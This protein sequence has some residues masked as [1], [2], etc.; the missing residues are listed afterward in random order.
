MQNFWPASGYA[1]LT[2]D[3]RGWLCPSEA[4][5]RRLVV[6]LPQLAL[7]EE[8]CPAEIALHQA[9]ADAPL[10]SV[11]EAQLAAL[12][13]ADARDNYRLFLSFRDTLLAAGTLE[14]YYL[15][16]MR[17][18]RITVPPLFVDLIVQAI[19]RHLL[20]D[21]H[22]AFEARA[23]E[24]LFRP[25]RLSLLDGRLIAADLATVDL[26]QETAGL[27]DIGRLLRQSQAPLPTTVLQVLNTDNAADYWADGERHRFALDL[28]H[29]ISNELGHG[30]AIRLV[31]AHSGL[32]ALASVLQR[33]LAHLLGLRVTITPLQ[34]IDDEAWRWHIGLDVE[35]MGLLNDLY[36]GAEVD[37]ERQ[38]RLISLFRL[39][40]AD[41]AEM[42][43][44][45]T[46]KP[47]YLG[48][49]MTADHTLRLKP[50]NLLLN[51]PLADALLQ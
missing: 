46:G 13:D 1:L 15:A 22:D 23:A 32:K 7:I 9:L 30:L 36:A 43:A 16:L 4:W 48:L 39:D 29:E 2:R 3:P 47:V 27:G 33:W 8:S 31:H 50:Q 5:L 19:V 25:Q 49:A 38:R 51:L 24:L 45:V 11:S 44:D 35:A 26:L 21:S 40:F 37:A 14:A 18:G 10:R 42:R 6:E 34:R 28:T 20:D 12:V 17:A 41:P